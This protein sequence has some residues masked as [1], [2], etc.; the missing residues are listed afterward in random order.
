[1]P[2]LPTLVAAFAAS[3]PFVLAAGAP[4]VAAASRV[5]QEIGSRGTMTVEQCMELLEAYGVWYAHED[6]GWVWQPHDVEPWWQP[7][8]VGEWIVTQDGSPYWR[9]GYPFGWAA[10]HYGSW[11]FDNRYGWLWVPG[12]EWSAAP[13]SWRAAGAVVGWA[14]QVATKS[15]TESEPCGQDAFAWIFV[16]GAALL[17]TTNFAA[18]ERDLLAR[19]AHGSW[20]GATAAADG[21]HKD[22]IPEPRNANLVRST[23]CLG[24]AEVGQAFAMASRAAGRTAIGPPL[25]FVRTRGQLGTGRVTNGVLPVYAPE[26]TGSVPPLSKARN[27]IRAPKVQRNDAAET[28]Y[29]AYRDQRRALDTHHDAQE[30]ALD[31]LHARDATNPPRE[32]MTPAELAAWQRRENLELHRMTARQRRLLEARQERNATEHESPDGADAGADATPA[33]GEGESA[34]GT[35]AGSN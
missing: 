29:D 31:A 8:S 5:Q 6:F 28:P 33:T 4:S 21:V 3:V 2:F 18:A 11:T 24:D 19:D 30:A 14:P 15:A 34:S 20:S 12:N 13:V 25:T 1:M 27:V 7:F 17:R 10:E 22:R 32:G 16:E 9:S 23:R 35:G 26:F